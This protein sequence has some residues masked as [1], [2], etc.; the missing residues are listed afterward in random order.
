MP[1]EPHFLLFLPLPYLTQS[2]QARWQ[3]IILAEATDFDSPTLDLTAGRFP[4]YSYTGFVDDIIVFYRLT[5]LPP[6]VLGSAGPTFVRPG[7]FQPIAGTMEFSSTFFAQ[8]F[9]TEDVILHEMAHALGLG[10][11][12]V[13]R[14]EE[15]ETGAAM[16]HMIYNG[17]NQD[18][19]VP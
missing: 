6:N 4:G 1:T 18:G 7:S 14:I 8:G 19:R 5:T 13:G 10:T 16:I 11:V 3:S 9:I 12:S 17:M 15:A 2:A